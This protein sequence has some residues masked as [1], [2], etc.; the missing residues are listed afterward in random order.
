MKNIEKLYMLHDDRDPYLLCTKEE[1]KQ[2]DRE[3]EEYVKTD[4]V[5][6]MIAACIKGKKPP[7]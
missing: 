3:A 2:L 1:L 7:K 6:Q 4:K 5:K